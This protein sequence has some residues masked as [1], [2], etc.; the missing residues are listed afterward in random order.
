MA[1]KHILIICGEASGDLN[2][3]NL[4]SALKAIQPDI[5]IS[6]V[7]GAH[8]ACTG[9]QIICDIKDLAVIGLFDVLK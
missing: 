1:E 7:G 3:A 8:L 4:A 2:A 6:G 5:K 9:A